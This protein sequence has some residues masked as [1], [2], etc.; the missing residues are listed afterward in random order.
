MQSQ[1]SCHRLEAGDL[2]EDVQGV[3]IPDD[4]SNADLFM[5]T[6]QPTDWYEEM[7]TLLQTGLFPFGITRDQ[8]KRLAVQS[9]HFQIIAG[10]VIS[11]MCG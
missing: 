9:R 4:F 5:V 2:A 6:I 8:R 11:K 10:A 7:L 3:G 1:I